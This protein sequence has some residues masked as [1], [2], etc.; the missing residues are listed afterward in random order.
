[1]QAPGGPDEDAS[2]D[3]KYGGWSAPY[4]DEVVDEVLEKQKKKTAD[5]LVGRKTFEIFASFWPEHED[6]W[7]GINDMTKHVMSNTMTKG[8]VATGTI[9]S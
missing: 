1:M 5:L 8:E 2:S 3:F 6:I 7:P 4:Y 9:G